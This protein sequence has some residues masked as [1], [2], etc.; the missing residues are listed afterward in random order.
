MS[1]VS[2][3]A[4]LCSTP[5]EEMSATFGFRLD[6]KNNNWIQKWCASLLLLSPSRMVMLPECLHDVVLSANIEKYRKKRWLIGGILPFIL[7]FIPIQS[8]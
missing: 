5:G 6:V 1:A 2:S 3:P 4:P 7:A 8:L